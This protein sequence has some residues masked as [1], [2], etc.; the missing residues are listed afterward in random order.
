MLNNSTTLSQLPVLSCPLPSSRHLG[1]LMGATDYLP[2]P[3]GRN[4][5]AGALARL[6]PAPQTVLVIDD[7]PHI[8]RLISRMLRS[9]SATLRVLEAFGGEEGLAV[10]RSQKP[11]AVF[12]D[13][14]MPG[15]SGHK[16]IEAVRQDRQLG[17]TPIIVVSVRS[18]EDETSPIVGEVRLERT[19]GFSLSELLAVVQ[20]MLATITRSDAISPANAAALLATAAD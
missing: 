18:V 6:T 20:S 4:D 10:V 11:D 1:T 19:T 16:F 15:M 8:V 2:K 12:V 5:L 7:D 14:M 9:I 13:L 17:Q 3:V